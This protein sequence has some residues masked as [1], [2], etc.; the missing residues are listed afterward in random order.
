MRKIDERSA[1][2]PESN[3]ID[4]HF[5]ATDNDIL[6]EIKTTNEYMKIMIDRMDEILA[7]L[8]E[9]TTTSSM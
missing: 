8:R 7:N 6:R 3:L 1:S 5:P 2:L 4:L 9:K